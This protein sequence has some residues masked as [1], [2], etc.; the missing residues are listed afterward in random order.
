MKY[1]NPFC[2]FQAPRQSKR[3]RP[4]VTNNGKT[5]SKSEPIT[6]RRKRINNT[7]PVKT[8]CESQA[9]LTISFTKKLF[10]YFM[11]FL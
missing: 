8:S 3:K 5:T 7:K 2:F 6:K 4:E 9:L 11:A 1:I 10:G